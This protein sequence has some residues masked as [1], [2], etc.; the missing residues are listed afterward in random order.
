VQSVL[1]AV[2]AAP[3]PFESRGAASRYFHEQGFSTALCSWMTTNVT[4][5]A[6]DQWGHLL[7]SDSDYDSDTDADSKSLAGVGGLSLS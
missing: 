3:V 4:E 7:D 5:A 1:E 6:V 2:C